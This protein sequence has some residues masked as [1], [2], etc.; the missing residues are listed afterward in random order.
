MIPFTITRFKDNALSE[1][2]THVAAEVPLTFEVN[3]REIVTLM[4]T[5]SHLKAF[6]YGFLVT[7]GFISSADDILSFSLD[8][9]RW[10]ADIEVKKWWIRIC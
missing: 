6:A 2:N 10:R 7:S 1:E 8:E 5:P 9:T 4:C 3:G